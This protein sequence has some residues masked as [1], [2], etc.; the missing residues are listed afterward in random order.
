M[1]E[2]RHV[3]RPELI[4]R[5]DKVVIFRAL[6]NKEAASVLNLQLAE[7]NDRL[8][9]QHQLTVELEASAKRLLLKKGYNAKSGV[10]AL[11][12]AIQD[13]L[14]DHLAEGLLANKYQPGSTVTVSA[15]KDELN[16]HVA[17]TAVRA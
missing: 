12:R 10:R 17:S 14:E 2:L 6:T 13:E 8:R 15:K 11:R 7:L 1:D 5:I 4:N 16:F 9:K 3:M